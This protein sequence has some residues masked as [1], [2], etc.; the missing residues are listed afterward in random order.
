M[1]AFEL[2]EPRVV[3][4]DLQNLQDRGHKVK[5]L[6]GRTFPNDLSRFTTLVGGGILRATG[7]GL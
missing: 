6:I 1:L 2:E 3:Q 7:K 4:L 5:M